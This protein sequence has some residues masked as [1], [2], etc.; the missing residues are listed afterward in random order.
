MTEEEGAPLDIK[1][2]QRFSKNLISNVVY[3]VLNVIIGLALV[4]FFLDTLGEAAYGLVPLATS[5][6]SYVTILLDSIN[7]SVSRYLAIDLQRGNLTHA[8]ET[9]NTALFGIMGIILLIVPVALVIAYYVPSFFDVGSET[10]LTVFILFSLIFG[11]LLIR[12]GSSNFMVILFAYNRLDLRNYVNIVNIASQLLIVLVLF[13]IGGPS[14]IYVGS[15]YFIAAC[16]SLILAVI[17]SKKISPDLHISFSKVT[18]KKFKEIGGMTSWVVFGQFGYLLR[19]QVALFIINILFGVTAETQYSLVLMWSTLL[20][21][22]ASLITNL[23]TPQSYS[24]RANDNKIGLTN[25]VSVST[26][27]TGLIMALPIALVCILSPQLF[28]LWVGPEYIFLTPLVWINLIP[29]MFKIQAS[30]IVP[31][32]MAYTKVKLPVILSIIA[33]C[34]N[35]VLAVILSSVFNLG[36]SGIAYATMFVLILYEG[37]FTPIYNAYI[38]NAP[39]ITFIKSMIPGMGNLIILSVCGVLFTKIILIDSIFLLIL[40]ICVI[41]ITYLILILKIEI[42]DTEKRMIRSCLPK[43]ISNHLPSWLL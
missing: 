9:F 38:I 19:T 36:L 20:I 14:L 8:N 24:Y 18:Q 10:N 5:L 37:I 33:G 23:F 12:T 27:L 25:F 11:S 31:I 35:V 22:I 28:T 29:L 32:Y 16:L 41:S 13:M 42:N 3:F 39:C 1:F 15:S 43:K 21:S 7:S 40:S 2:Q 26:K 30:C 4:P 34:L 6:T 17:L